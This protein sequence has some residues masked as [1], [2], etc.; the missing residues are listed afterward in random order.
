[1]N[2]A[3]GLTSSAGDAVSG[4]MLGCLLEAGTERSVTPE[5]ESVGWVISL[6]YRDFRKPRG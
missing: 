6:A 1:M 4:S 5:Y 3:L 2:A